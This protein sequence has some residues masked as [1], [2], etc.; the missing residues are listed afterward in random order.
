MR[1]VLQLSLLPARSHCWDRLELQQQHDPIDEWSRSCGEIESDSA[2]NGRD[3]ELRVEAAALQSHR[4]NCTVALIR[5][6][7]STQV[8][9][10]SR[11]CRC[12]APPWLC[13][14]TSGAERND[15]APLGAQCR[16][17]TATVRAAECVASTWSARDA[18]HD[19]HAGVTDTCAWHVLLRA[20][21]SGA[22][23]YT[24]LLRPSP[25]RAHRGARHVCG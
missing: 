5:R 3:S 19:V 13:E 16:W 20:P 14:S 17:A 12:V 9:R 2:P 1:C 18:Y 15:A 22:V 25:L 7:P 6:D 8:D 24:A 11:R 23:R 10:V 21:W 4:H